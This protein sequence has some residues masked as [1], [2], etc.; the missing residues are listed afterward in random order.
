M[1]LKT[2]RD[3]FRR[4]E[5]LIRSIRRMEERY[6]ELETKA[7]STGSFRYDQEKVK[8]SLPDGSRHEK[9]VVLMTVVEKEIRK[10]KEE[11]D[12]VQQLIR[13]LIGP[14]MMP[15][16]RSTMIYRHVEHH[17]PEECMQHFGYEYETYKIY[18]KMG[19]KAMQLR[20]DD[21]PQI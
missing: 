4:E 11:L 1:E 12:E 6:E 9:I 13:S 18:H 8:G 2:V 16:I 10:K 19:M 3:L 14:I 5:D 17:T 20:L 21:V 7:T 15:R